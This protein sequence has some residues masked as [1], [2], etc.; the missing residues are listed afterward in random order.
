MKSLRFLKALRMW[1]L[2]SSFK[3]WEIM[4][5]EGQRACLQV[6]Q[7]KE[8]IGC[9]AIQVCESGVRGVEWVG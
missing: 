9:W 6:V 3:L 2:R 7:E 1:I 5:G 4:A 8:Q